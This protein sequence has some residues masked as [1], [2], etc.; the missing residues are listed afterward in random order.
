MKVNIFE[1]SLTEITSAYFEHMKK[2]LEIDLSSASE[3]LVMAAYLLEMKSK[4][5]L[6]QPEEIELR[7]EEEEVEADLAKHLAEYNIFKEAAEHLKRQKEK[8]SRIYSRY[9]KEHHPTHEKA[10]FLLTDVNLNDLV[11]AFQKVYNIFAEEEKTKPIILDEVSLTQ[12]VEEIVEIIRGAG[13]EVEFEKLFIRR[14]RMEVV[15]TFLAVLELCRQKRIRVAQEGR[16]SGINLRF[17]K[18]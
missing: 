16:F 12:R 17:A 6:P 11:T 2:L 8:F 10:D 3:F 18:A 7:R 5:L 1:I 9:H 15:V 13:G 14:T 4:K